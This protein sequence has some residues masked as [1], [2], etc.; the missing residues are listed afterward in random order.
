[1][2]KITT[3]ENYSQGIH[4]RQIPLLHRKSNDHR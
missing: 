2:H 4:S 3:T 1:M